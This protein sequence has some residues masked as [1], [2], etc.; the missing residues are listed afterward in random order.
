MERLN[1]NKGAKSI[2]IAELAKIQ[3][4]EKV[5]LGNYDNDLILRTKGSIV[6]QIQNKFY[7]AEG[8]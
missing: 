1:I 2:Q 4:K 6:V 7:Q 3:D 5:V 8:R